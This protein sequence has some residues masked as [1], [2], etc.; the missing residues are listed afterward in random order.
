MY[1]SLEFIGRLTL[2][3]VIEESE[4]ELAVLKALYNLVDDDGK[5]KIADA[6]D[7]IEENIKHKLQ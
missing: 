7:Q 4:M 3:L 2:Q 6:I 5:R 1:M